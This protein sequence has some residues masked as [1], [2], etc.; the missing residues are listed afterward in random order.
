ML[1]DEFILILF[2][3]TTIFGCKWGSWSFDLFGGDP[4]NEDSDDSGDNGDGGDGGDV[5]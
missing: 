4:I 3:L 2:I 5:C 1:G